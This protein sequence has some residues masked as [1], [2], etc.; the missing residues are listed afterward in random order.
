MLFPI[1]DDD[2]KISGPVY[3]TW[4][5]IAANVAAFALQLANPTLTYAWSMIPFEIVNNTDLVTPELIRVGSRM[6]ELTHMPGPEPIQLT[7]LSSMFMHGGLAHIGGNMLYLWIFGDNVEHRFGHGWFLAFYLVSGL[8]GTALQI[9]LGPESTI[10]NLGASGAISGVL[11]AYIVLFPRNRVYTIVFYAIV[12]LPAILVIGLW[13]AMQMING[14]GSIAQTAQTGGVAYGAHVGGFLAG[15]M[16][17]LIYRV[18]KKFEPDSLMHRMYDRD[19]K[20]RQ[21]W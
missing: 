2:A 14:V 19:P 7:L 1:S 16:M 4:C 21:L 17:A 13:A 5:L 9:V 12:A 18:R 8:A 11:G 10:P 20:A 15:V 3:V 6:A